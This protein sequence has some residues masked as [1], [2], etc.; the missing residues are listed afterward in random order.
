MYLEMKI[1]A[2]NQLRHD[3]SLP[4]G[5]YLFCFQF[6]GVRLVMNIQFCPVSRLLLRGSYFRSYGLPQQIAVKISGRMISFHVMLD[7][8]RKL[9]KYP[10]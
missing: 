1:K 10:E 8:S 2:V 3:G 7:M 6:D 9:Y 4:Q 5:A